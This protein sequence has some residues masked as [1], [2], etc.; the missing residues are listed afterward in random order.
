MPG[1]ELRERRERCFP[2]LE[3]PPWLRWNRRSSL[4]YQSG[5]GGRNQLLVFWGLASE[6]LHGWRPLGFVHARDGRGYRTIG[7]PPI[8]ESNFSAGDFSLREVNA[9]FETHECLASPRGSA[10]GAGIVS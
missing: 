8:P 5:L 3:T 6:A 2:G 10:C 9:L 1:N 7:Y 4:S